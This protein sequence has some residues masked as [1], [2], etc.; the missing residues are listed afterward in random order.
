MDT[1]HRGTCD[2]LLLH[3]VIETSSDFAFQ[4]NLNRTNIKDIISENGQISCI[5]E[6][7]KLNVDASEELQFKSPL[8]LQSL[9]TDNVI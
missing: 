1:R 5:F 7:K 2:V 8:T 9:K 6:R 4:M 3:M